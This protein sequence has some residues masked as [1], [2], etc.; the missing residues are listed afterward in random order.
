MISERDKIAATYTAEGQ[1][2]AQK[3]RN[4]TDR[5]IAISIS[6][7]R[8]QAASITAEGEAEYMRIMAEAYADPQKTE[9]YSYARAL[10]AARASLTG[11]NNT[12]ILPANSPIARIFMGQ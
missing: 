4:T 8:A 11:N 2:E 7:A 3:I 10:E 9:F 1:A 12:L 5:E 6:D